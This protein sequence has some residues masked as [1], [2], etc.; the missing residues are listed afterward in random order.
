ME[1]RDFL[2]KLCESAH[3]SGYESEGAEIVRQ[4]FA[5]YLPDVSTD[6]FGNVVGF[7]KGRGKGRLMLTGHMDEIGLMVA[8]IDEKGFVRFTTIGGFDERVFPAQEVIIHGREKIFGVI[9]IKPPHILPPEEL[10][11]VFKAEDL[12]IDTGYGR[13]KLSSLIAVGDII[14]MRSKAADLRNGCLSAK[15]MD[16]SVGVATLFC[17]MKYLR[18][19]D[20]DLDVYFVATTQEEVGL[21]GATTSAYTIEPD[22]AIAIDVGFAKTP[23]V[24]DPKVIDMGMGP[25][26]AVGPAIHPAIFE[27]LKKTAKDANLKY[28]VEALPSRTGTDADSMQISGVGVATGVISVPLKYMHTPVETVMLSDIDQTGRLL[29]EFIRA[30]DDVEL[31]DALCL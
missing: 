8:D 22:I 15:S 18:R 19:V 21:H 7:K 11:K 28:Q 24:S 4:A 29:A 25:A 27:K 13:D 10:N 6:K 20:H 17:A 2:I 3:V 12:F 30:F 1:V 31:E 16:D 23:D 5:E 26:I 9:G 14:T